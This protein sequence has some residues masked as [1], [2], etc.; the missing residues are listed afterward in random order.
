MSFPR[1]CPPQ[2]SQPSNLQSSQLS[3]VSVYK[4]RSNKHKHTNSTLR[5]SRRQQRKTRRIHHPQPLHT[6]HPRPRVNHSHRIVFLAH[7]TGTR[8]VPV[9]IAALH[10]VL[11]YV[12]V[13]SDVSAWHYFFDDDRCHC[14]R[15]EEGARALERLHCDFA[16][17]GMGEVIWVHDGEIEGGV[18]G[19]VHPASGER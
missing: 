19:D 7:P 12:F 15:L 18:G 11:Q 3:R 1:G 9:L 6:N 17:G 13:T 4:C 5:M 14:F 2:S 8:S 10:D 16:V